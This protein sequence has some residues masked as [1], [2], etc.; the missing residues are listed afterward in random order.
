MS[1]NSEAVR[2]QFP[3]LKK[4][5]NGHRLVYLDSAASAQKPQVVIETLRDV[6][7]NTYAN[8]HRGIYTLADEATERY[9]AARAKV[10][11][12]IN[13]PEP[14]EIIY[15]RNATEALNLVAYSW[16]RANIHSNSRI[17]LTE[18]EHHSNMV[19]WQELA[20]EKDAELTY[21]P[22]T[23][24]G[25]L[26]LSALPPLLEDGRANLVAFSLMSNV[27]G[28]ITQATEI[29]RLAHDAGA[30][31]MLDGAQAVPHIPVDVQALDADF[32]AFSGHKLG[33]PGIGALWGRRE[34]LEA[35]PPFLYGGDMIRTV[36]KEEAIWNELP[37]KFEAGTPAIAEAIAFGA[38]IDFLS[39]LDMDAVH[40]HELEMVT[41]AMERLPEVPGLH[42]LG[43][44]PEKRG[45]AIA[46][47]LDGIHP[48]DVAS[49][50]DEQGICVRAGLHCAEPLHRRFKLPA[51]VRA[52]YY[53]YNTR[54]DTDALVEGLHTVVKILRR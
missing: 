3:I 38:A 37:Y 32:L 22:V 29:I 34:L 30:I 50:L 42:I 54:A 6:Y 16:G 39:E 36:T 25:E 11:A 48:H 7:T 2:A 44:A 31:V 5:I 12:F 51:T 20:R 14:E 13:A 40:Q 9:E 15:V 8:V 47:S 41:Y 21:I 43:P 45:G 35:M 10:A 4:E 27:M 17:I 26:E 52:S 1:W 33:A 23:D 28:T 19:P 53:I 18:L 24:N 49:I 46:F